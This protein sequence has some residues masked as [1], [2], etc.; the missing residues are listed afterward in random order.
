M[1]DL[2]NETSFLPVGAIFALVSAFFYAAYLVFLRKKVEHEDKLDI[3]LFFG[4]LSI[5]QQFKLSTLLT[6]YSLVDILNRFRWLVQSTS[7]LAFILCLQ[8][9][10][11]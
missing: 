6:K 9:H 11:N 1:S 3:P 5:L 4:T 2:R 7:P 8:L 10:W